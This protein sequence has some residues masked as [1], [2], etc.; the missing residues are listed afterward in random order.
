MFVKRP[1]FV[2]PGTDFL[3]QTIFLEE[4]K[5]RSSVIVM[6]KNVKRSQWLSLFY[7]ISWQKW[8]VLFFPSFLSGSKFD[9]SPNPFCWLRRELSLKIEMNRKGPLEGKFAELA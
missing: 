3:F 1:I 6:E 7:S 2:F 5:K 9:M 8:Y 4:K